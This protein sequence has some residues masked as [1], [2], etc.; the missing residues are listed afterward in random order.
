MET[1]G[2]GS[3]HVKTRVNGKS[4]CPVRFFYEPEISLENEI[5]FHFFN[6]KQPGPYRFP[7]REKGTVRD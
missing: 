7:R 5:Y 4:H 2:G 3:T 1:I 6:I